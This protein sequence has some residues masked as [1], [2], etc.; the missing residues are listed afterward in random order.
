MRASWCFWTPSS[1]TNF[2][3][4]FQSKHI[5]PHLN[6]TGMTNFQD[7]CAFVHCF[8][9]VY[10]FYLRHGTSIKM[11]AVRVLKAYSKCT[12]EWLCGRKH[13][14]IGKWNICLKRKWFHLRTKFWPLQSGHVFGLTEIWHLY[15]LRYSLTNRQLVPVRNRKANI[16][17]QTLKLDVIEEL[18]KH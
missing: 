10:K 14:F 12:D 9:V 17:F 18:A 7:D 16:F 2:A 13:R 3:H 5:F 6:A 15:F 4:Q 1:M 11:S 8:L